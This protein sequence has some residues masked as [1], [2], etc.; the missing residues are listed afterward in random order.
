MSV[1]LV[2]ICI[3]FRILIFCL[4]VS[5]VYGVRKEGSARRFGQQIIVEIIKGNSYKLQ[6]VFRG[7]RGGKRDDEVHDVQKNR[8]ISSSCC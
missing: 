1:N 4:F 7:K 3:V 5:F 8:Q 6:H 2:M